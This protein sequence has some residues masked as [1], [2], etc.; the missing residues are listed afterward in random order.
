[1]DRP[2]VAVVGP[3]NHGHIPT[4][5]DHIQGGGGE[6]RDWGS[7][8][9]HFCATLSTLRCFFFLYEPTHSRRLKSQLLPF[10]S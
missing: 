5:R 1:M 6:G 9:T 3:A 4:F 7:S 10:E 8:A 2:V